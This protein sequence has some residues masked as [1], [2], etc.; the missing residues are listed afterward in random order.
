MLSNFQINDIALIA[1][2]SSLLV[3]GGAEC[4]F[5]EKFY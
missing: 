1:T 5:N 4:K 2:K 3:A